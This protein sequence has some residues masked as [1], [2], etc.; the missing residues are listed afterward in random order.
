MGGNVGKL[1]AEVKGLWISASPAP[2]EGAKI[3]TPPMFQSTHIYVS[4]VVFMYEYRVCVALCATQTSL[5][6]KGSV[7]LYLASFHSVAL[8]R[9]V[10][11]P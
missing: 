3:S 6:W 10:T 1:K 11:R 9:V 5:G 2:L 4:M 7:H 8:I